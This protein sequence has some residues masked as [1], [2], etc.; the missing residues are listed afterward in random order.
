[1]LSGIKKY[2][3]EIFGR[4][5]QFKLH[6]TSYRLEKLGTDY[7]GWIVPVDLL[8]EHSVCYLAGAGED[9]SFDVALAKKFHCDVFIFDPTPRARLH[10]DK[11]LRA[12]SAGQTTAEINNVQYTLDKNIINH[13]HFSD[14]GIWNSKDVL[15]FFEPKDEAHISHSITNLQGTEKYIEVRVETLADIMR[16]NGHSRLDMLKLDIEG[17]EFTVLDSISDIDI[18]IL[19]V[20]FHIQQDGGHDLVQSTIKKLEANQF[21]VIAREHFDFTF[22]KKR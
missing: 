9:I 22:I 15:K 10:F 6:R 19:C 8:N 4:D 12:A 20:E 18:Q 11:V 21:A 14:I 1:M 3:K 5:L 16:S 7:G 13:L 2:V 17:A